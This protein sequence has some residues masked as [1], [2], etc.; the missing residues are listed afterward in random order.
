VNELSSTGGSALHYAAYGGQTNAVRILLEHGA[1]VNASD[2]HGFTSLHQAVRAR[3]VEI[4]QLLLGGE[5]DLEACDNDG[6]TP[7]LMAAKG[8]CIDEFR[9]LIN[10]GADIDA[11]DNEKLGVEALAAARHHADILEIIQN[12]RNKLRRRG[13]E[14]APVF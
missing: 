4:V 3:H 6:R 5:A 1:D 9:E 11:T 13:I 14:N 7:L 8:G 2:R 12:H 10:S